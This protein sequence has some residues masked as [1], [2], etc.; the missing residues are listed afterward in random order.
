MGRA[1]AAAPRGTSP[2]GR[3]SW[4]ARPKA[5]AA[6][7]APTCRRQH[8][9]RLCGNTP[10][11]AARRSE[12]IRLA[13]THPVREC[14]GWEFIDRGAPA[15]CPGGGRHEHAG[16]AAPT[17]I[18]LHRPPPIMGITPR[19]AGVGAG[20]GRGETLRAHA[21]PAGGRHALRH[22]VRHWFRPRPLPRRTAGARCAAVAICARHH[23]AA[24]AAGG[25]APGFG[26]YRHAPAARHGV[27][28]HWHRGSAD[29]HAAGR[30]APGLCLR[31]RDRSCDTS[32]N[33]AH[34][35]SYRVLRHGPLSLR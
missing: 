27:P 32:W 22:R 18:A 24:L 14:T 26:G 23:A 30:V 17:R 10:E 25:V 31:H 16:C 2:G 15:P 11:C 33:Y 13:R 5:R 12:C 29:A 35:G 20:A 21:R 9:A 34:Q 4:S 6:K 8:V 3:A 1:A 7:T 28:R 19:A